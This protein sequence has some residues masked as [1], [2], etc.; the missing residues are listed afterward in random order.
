MRDILLPW[1]PLGERSQG[2]LQVHRRL[3]ASKHRG[4]GGVV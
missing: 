4:C 2:Q 3:T 1:R